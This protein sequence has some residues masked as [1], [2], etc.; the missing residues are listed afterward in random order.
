MAHICTLF[1]RV[2]ACGE[3]S[4]ELNTMDAVLTYDCRFSQMKAIKQ[5]IVYSPVITRY[6]EFAS[7]TCIHIYIYTCVTLC[8]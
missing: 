2:F 3:E 6:T 5:L 1:E 8:V 4:V 7:H